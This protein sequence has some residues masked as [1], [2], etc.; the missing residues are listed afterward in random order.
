[1]E[2]ETIVEEGVTISGYVLEF[3]EYIG[4]C[5]DLLEDGREDEI[6]CDP[7]YV[8]DENREYISDEKVDEVINA[9]DAEYT[10]EI[11]TYPSYHRN[12]SNSNATADFSRLSKSARRGMVEGI[13]RIISKWEKIEAEEKA[14]LP[15]TP[16]PMAPSGDYT[17]SNYDESFYWD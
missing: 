7:F 3:I 17:V 5:F 15:P 4:N 16:E 8:R 14:A 2:Y 9:I 12:R 11:G 1:M 10:Y 6:F 13:D